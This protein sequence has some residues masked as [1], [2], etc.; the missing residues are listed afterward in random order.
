MMTLENSSSRSQ[1]GFFNESGELGGNHARFTE[2]CTAL[3]ERELLALSHASTNNVS[4]LKRRIGGLPYHVR[5][6]ARFMVTRPQSV[7]PLDVDTHNG[8]WFCKQPSKC[9]G[10][11]Q[12]TEKCVQW[13]KKH[14]AYGLVVPVLVQS[15][16]GMCIE[17]DSIDMFN[18]PQNNVH[19]N[20]HGWFNLGVGQITRTSNVNDV[21]T[22]MVLSSTALTQELSDE[23]AQKPFASRQLSSTR[24]TLLKPTKTIM[25][26]ACCGHMWNYKSKSN[27][28]SLSI[29]EMRLSTQVNWK[30]FSLAK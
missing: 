25:S 1:S 14:L 8:S 5:S 11:N 7:L 19:L 20:K 18:E 22:E 23:K 17:L 3:Y 26:S 27:P 4:I 24:L 13:Y 12:E 28:R 2:V 16:E 10:L 30:N 9:P 21:T 15:V 6:V 29:R